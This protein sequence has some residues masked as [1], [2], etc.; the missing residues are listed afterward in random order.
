MVKTFKYILWVVSA[1]V[2]C[3]LFYAISVPKPPLTLNEEMELRRVIERNNLDLPRQIGTIGTLDSMKYGNHTITYVMSVFGEIET[4]ELYDT[5]YDE[6]GDLL[7]YTFVIMNGQNNMGAKFASVLKTK[8]LN[9]EFKVFTPGRD[10]TSWKFT[11]KD[12]Y[13]FVISCKQSPTTA[14]RTT[15]DMQIE[16]ASINLPVRLEDLRSD[17]KSV[18]L[19]SFLSDLDESCLPQ[20]IAHTGDDIIFVYEVD[21]NVYDLSL[22]E[23][24]FAYEKAQEEYAKEMTSDADVMELFGLIVMSHSNMVVKL[25][26]RQSGNMVE[27]TIPYEIL[28]KYCKVPY[29]LLSQ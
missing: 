27:V 23:E 21:E 6:F 10:V 9:I 29:Y 24:D 16:I 4:K 26:G 7:K 22:F 17:V 2:I 25:K 14:L 13:D 8:Q 1:I 20:S 12:I 3:G 11:G 15:I 5:H 18:A 28:K 19:N